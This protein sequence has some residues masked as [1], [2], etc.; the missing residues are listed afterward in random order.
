MNVGPSGFLDVLGEFVV[1]IDGEGMRGGTGFFVGRG[2]V[3]TCAHVVAPTPSGGTVRAATRARVSWAGRRAEGT[4]TALPAE[5]RGAGLWGYPD[6]AVIA[7]DETAPDHPWVPMTTDTP[8]LGRR[9]C[10]AGYSAVYGTVPQLGASSVEYE[11]PL[12]TAGG[13][14]LQLKNGELA[15]GKSGGPLI[16]L[17]RGEV[18]AIVTTTRRENLDMGG[19]AIPVTAL[20]A[21][22]P[23]VW[24]ANR[25]PSTL[26]GRLWR[27]RAALDHEYGPGA[28]LSL[29]EEQALLAAARGCGLRPA[30]LFWRSVH[31]DYG[32][33]A[34]PLDDMADVLREVADAPAGIDGV[35]PL[36][37]FAELITTAVRPEPGDPLTGLAAQVAE[38]L[39]SSVSQTQTAVAPAPSPQA[40]S[41]AEPVRSSDR[42][43]AI[44]V[45]LDSPG[46]D[47]EHYLLSVWKY[48]DIS[49][50]PHPLLCED[51]PL[52][53]AK[54]QERFRAVVPW[55]VGEL[56]EAGGIVLLEFVL[57]TAKLN[58]V[59]VDTWYLSQEWAPLSRQYP[60]VLR[61]L[62]RPPETHPSWM[63]RWRQL[64]QSARTAAP[65]TLDW[66]DC[67]DDA[68]PAQLFARYQ[69]QSGMSVLALAVSP[70]DGAGRHALET[71]LYA[72]LPAAVWTRSGCAGRCPLAGDRSSGIHDGERPSCPGQ[73][74]RQA[75][76]KAFAD[77]AP[78]DLPLIVMQ[79]RVASG[80]K[81]ADPDHCGAGL[82]LLWDDAT[83]RLPGDGPPLRTPAHTALGGA[84]T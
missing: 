83:R 28:V 67:R 72:G 59:P 1:R 78:T 70:G 74:F 16:D 34:S 14:V 25:V 15:A 52:T 13:E 11:G 39:G 56:A 45:Y 30:A 12:S 35:H 22:F 51:R 77:S 62:D 75:V 65:E 60:V 82:I 55:A 81:D 18:C 24:A 66:F 57:P 33:P 42:V 46:L 17:E 37:T 50:P 26:A 54:A 5:H 48:P 61:V 4:V 20:N 71:A 49:G 80:T 63:A 43:A 41:T 76:D 84:P 21:Y 58:E 53:L 29:R 31:P 73:R 2:L 23:G 47:D 9:L 64:R 6:L 36:V 32:E 68:V 69:E 40:F 3:V 27:L 19:L 44:S 79:L 8:S 7:L 10:A 38:R